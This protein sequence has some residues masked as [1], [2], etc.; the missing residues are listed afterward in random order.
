MTFRDTVVKIEKKEER[1]KY[2]TLEFMFVFTKLNEVPP[3]LVQTA[4]NYEHL[5]SDWL[6]NL[7][8]L[9]QHENSGLLI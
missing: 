1:I 4:R 8:G 3:Y 5:E 6:C 7:Q 9:V 2:W